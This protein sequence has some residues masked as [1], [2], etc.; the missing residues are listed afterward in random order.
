MRTRQRGAGVLPTPRVFDTADFTGPALPCLHPF[1]NLT[2]AAPRGYRTGMLAD[3]QRDIDPDQPLSLDDALL[4]ATRLHR[5]T[6][7][8]EARELYQAVLG[9]APEHPQTLQFLGILEH[10]SHNSELALSYFERALAQ[11]PESAGMHQNLGN[12]LLELSR[13]EAAA[14]AYQRAAQLGGNSAE[15][16][17]NSAVLSRLAGRVDAAER[18]YREA[19]AL[20]P[21]YLD[22]YHAYGRLL[23]QQGR[24]KEAL[25][26]YS[27][28]VT[29]DSARAGSHQRL[30]VALCILG[31]FQEATQV[32]R[33]WVAS[34]PDNPQAR[35]YLAAC[36]G[37]GVP[38]RAPDA[39]VETTFDEFA[40]SFDAKLEAL[41][42]RAPALIG[43][44]VRRLLGEPRASREVLDAG[45]GTGLC[46]PV[47]APYARRLV[48]VDL[49]VGMLT[50]AKQRGGYDAL[51]KV[52]LGAFLTA[53]P[54]RFDLIISADTLCYFGALDAALEAAFRAL[55]AGGHLVFTLEAR[56]SV[57]SNSVAMAPDSGFVLTPY[58]RY[59]HAAEYVER[60]LRG[61]GFV[62]PGLRP[63]VL[64]SEAAEPVR[65]YV[66]SA[67]RPG[68]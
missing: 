46:A 3:D 53:Q 22:G 10:Q 24:H 7:L 45:C 29:R 59:A 16:L 9:I 44:E 48:G 17:C 27:E 15:L 39:Y 55:R 31:R 50:R 19:L 40:Q 5:L 33:D 38:E 1:R 30:G 21:T 64:R 25:L 52:E 32:Y 23:A 6:H 62:Q 34:E 51:F 57:A 41:Q 54:E 61:A 2:S 13:F 58:G 26:Q 36:T 63:V 8:N 35:H 20:D 65:G 42:Y 56:V 68:V 60:V 43:E 49:S 11:Q 12:V 28:A 47:L 66:V 18:A 4:L 37:E 67:L 14:A